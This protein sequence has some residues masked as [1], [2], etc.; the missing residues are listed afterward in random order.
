MGVAAARP[1]GLVSLLGWLLTGAVV[2]F[3][4]LSLP[5]VGLA[6]LAIAVVAAAAA[7]WD[8]A[9]PWLLI[10]A[11]LPLLWVAWKNRGGPGEACVTS[12]ASA[13]CRE[14]LDPLPWLLVGLGLAGLGVVVLLVG[15]ARRRAR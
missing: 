15:R 11:T 9:L 1:G 3:F 2:A 6:V 12:A 10:G 4:G 7:R 13:G 8:W 5:S 14:L